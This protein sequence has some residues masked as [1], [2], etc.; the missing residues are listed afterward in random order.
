MP[1]TEKQKRYLIH[2]GL[3]S[4]TGKE[5]KL[6]DYY[7]L[8]W[9]MRQQV[10]T[11]QQAADYLSFK[12]T[13]VNYFLTR[14]PVIKALEDR[15]IP[16]KQHTQ[17]ELT[18]TQIATAITLSNFADDRTRE[19]KLDQLGVNPQQF[20]AWLNDPQFKNLIETLADEN[21]KNIKPTALAEFTRLINQ[22]D[23]QAIKYY[24]ETTG[25]LRNNDAPQSEQLLKMIVEIIQRHV[26][27]PAIIIAIAQDI[28]NASQNRTLEVVTHHKEI[29]GEVVSDE[30]VENAR[31]RLGI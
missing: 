12:V 23:W 14:R 16:W 25:A 13:E 5:R 24:L 17:S 21:V 19:E 4:I 9:F 26:Q 15:G 29:T 11:V 28:K 1:L 31:R 27:D 10:P 3:Q 18:T 8:L 30:V 6:V 2:K 7:E 22:G 20:Y